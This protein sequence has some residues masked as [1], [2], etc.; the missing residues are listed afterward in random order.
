MTFSATF[1]GNLVV[2]V[3]LHRVRGATLAHRAQ[4]GGVPEH[5]RQRHARDDLDR[6]TT[7]LLTLDPS[8]TAREVTDDI[9][10]VILRRDDGDGEDGLEQRRAC[11][12]D[13]LLGTQGAGDLERDL[14]RVGVVR[15]AVDERELGRR[16]AG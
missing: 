9:A 1:G 2:A 12:L 6:V 11:A 8:T 15:L 10:D 13:G 14:R 4:V 3:E 5:L 7:T 16:R